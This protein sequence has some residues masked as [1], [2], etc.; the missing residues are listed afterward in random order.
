MKTITYKKWC[1][2][3]YPPEDIIISFEDEKMEEL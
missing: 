1:K 2:G 3:N